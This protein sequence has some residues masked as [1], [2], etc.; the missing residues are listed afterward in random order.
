LKQFH[1]SVVKP[2]YQTAAGSLNPAINR[3]PDRKT[4]L[5]TG[6]RIHRRTI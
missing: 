6:G 3:R 2:S 5:S 1:F 4:Q